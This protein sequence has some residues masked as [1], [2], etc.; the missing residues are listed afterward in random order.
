MSDKDITTR[1]DTPPGPPASSAVPA[2]LPLEAGDYLAE[3]DALEISDAQK[4]ELLEILWSIMSEFVRIGFEMDV[5]TAVFGDDFSLFAADSA[6]VDSP[7]TPNTE[8]Q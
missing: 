3:L 5:C 4:R 7:S 8:T 1:P 2:A 6:G